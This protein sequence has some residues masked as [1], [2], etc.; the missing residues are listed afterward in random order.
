[1]ALNDAS[2]FSSNLDRISHLFVG[3]PSVVIYLLAYNSLAVSHF[4]DGFISLRSGGVTVQVRKYLREDGKTVEL[5]AMSHIGDPEFYQIFTASFSPLATV[6]ME[7]V[8]GKSHL[9]TEPVGHTKTAKDL[10][11][12]EQHEVFKPQGKLIAPDVDLSEFSN[13]T[14]DCLKE[15]MVIHTTGLTAE[16]LPILMQPSSAE[17]P[18]QLFNDLL[19]RRNEHLLEV[20]RDQLEISDHVIVPWGAAHM[21]GISAGGLQAGFHL[22]TSKDYMAVRFSGVKNR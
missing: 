4:T 15:T 13:I 16:T 21:P 20:L 12:A 3:V 14:L 8:S 17:L 7:G 2:V 1:M 19:T 6:L 18:Q 10:G 11:L 22:Q 5:V 9:M